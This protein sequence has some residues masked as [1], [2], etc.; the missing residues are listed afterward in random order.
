MTNT[1]VYFL[2]LIVCLFSSCEINNQTNDA[3]VRQINEQT[4]IIIPNY[5]LVNEELTSAFGDYSQSF[6]LC[7]DSVEFQALLNEISQS[8]A[9]GWRKYDSGYKYDIVLPNNRTRFSYY[10]NTSKKTL[11]Y[12]YIEE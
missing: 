1:S 2:F 6:L 4:G 8:Q 9:K 12:L 10:L 11:Y 3:I 5:T 7:F